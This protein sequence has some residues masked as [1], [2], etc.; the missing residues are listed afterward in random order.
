MQLVIFKVF[1]LGGL[2]CAESD[3]QSNSGNLGACTGGLVESF[4][5][6]VQSRGRRGDRAPFA[7]E[8]GLVALPVGGAVAAFDVGRQRHV[9]EAVEGGVHV[10]GSGEPDRAFAAFAVGDDLGGKVVVE[11]NCLAD[12]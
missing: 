9:A 10:F 8:D 5:G 7:G 4:L 3:M 6:E 2:E 1:A 12:P 11:A